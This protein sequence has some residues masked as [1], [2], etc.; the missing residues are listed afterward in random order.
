MTKT[1]SFVNIAKHIK[2]LKEN[3]LLRKNNEYGFIKYDDKTYVEV[4][5]DK[6]EVD[7]WYK[8]LENRIEQIEIEIELKEK[9][10]D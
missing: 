7:S 10:N 8:I 2:I 4:E 1:Q 3:I 6:N 5:F 9:Q